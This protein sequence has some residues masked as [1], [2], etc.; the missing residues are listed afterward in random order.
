MQAKRPMA[1]HVQVQLAMAAVQ[2][3]AAAAAMQCIAAAAAAPSEILAAEPEPVKDA[4]FSCE[5]GTSASAREILPTNLNE[6]ERLR[7]VLRCAVDGK[8]P[9]STP[10][11]SYLASVRC[12]GYSTPPGR[13]ASPKGALFSRCISAQS[14]RPREKR[15]G[16]VAGLLRKYLYINPS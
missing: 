4:N 13:W 10:S 5:F 16:N 14:Q 6:L 11:W 8:A 1:E 7:G 15:C 2:C 12:G 3:K 9:K